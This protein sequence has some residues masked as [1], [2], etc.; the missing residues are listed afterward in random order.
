VD[1]RWWVVSADLEQAPS[2][3]PSDVLLEHHSIVMR[4]VHPPFERLRMEDFLVLL[5]CKFVRRCPT[6]VEHVSN[7]EERCAVQEQRYLK[8]FLTYLSTDLCG[9]VSAEPNPEKG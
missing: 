3:L 4:H 7:C 2:L 5:G 9:R 6:Q 1:A 8:H